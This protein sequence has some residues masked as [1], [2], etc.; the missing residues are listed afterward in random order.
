MAYPAFEV[1]HGTAGFEVGSEKRTS[2]LWMCVSVC[3]FWWESA[4]DQSNIH[5]GDISVLEH[6]SRA[7]TKVTQGVGWKRVGRTRE[8]E[9]NLRLDENQSATTEL[10]ALLDHSPFHPRAAR[11][12]LKTVTN[13]SWCSSWFEA[14]L[15]EA[16]LQPQGPKELT[17]N[18]PLTHVQR[19]HTHTR[20]RGKLRQLLGTR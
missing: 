19:E 8:P 11:A 17:F 14:P 13:V 16:G 2:L 1:P 15:Y 9:S 5:S 20:H 4:S 3:V 6:N 18:V 12:P 7:M 10:T